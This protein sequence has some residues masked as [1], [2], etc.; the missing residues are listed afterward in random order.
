MNGTERCIDDEIPF[1]IPESWNWCRLSSL[2]A[3]QIR[4]GK[5]PKYST[6]IGIQVFAQKCN[7][8]SGGIDMSLAKYLDNSVLKKYPQEEYLQHQDIIINSTGKGTLGRIG[9]FLDSDRLDNSIVVPDSHV[10][11]IR[12]LPLI[13]K[14]YTLYVLKYYQPF[15]EKAGSGS[16]N[17]TE[18]KPVTIANL[19]IPL[20][21]LIEQQNIGKKITSLLSNVEQL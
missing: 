2:V 6:D 12:L 14:D 8:K 21:S 15:L 1:E 16:T 3:K 11:V 10:T 19:L 7:L 20:P 18:L 4:R 13:D 5:S 17:Q 9:I